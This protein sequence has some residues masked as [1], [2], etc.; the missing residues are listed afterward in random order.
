MQT[1]SLLNE[2]CDLAHNLETSLKK[3]QIERH[4]IDLKT[5][6]EGKALM[7]QQKSNFV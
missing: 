3:F 5:N 7:R 6:E 1:N 2:A 4:A